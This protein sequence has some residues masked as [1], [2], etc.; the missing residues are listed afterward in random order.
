MRSENQHITVEDAKLIAAAIDAIAV[1]AGR[2]AALHKSTKGQHYRDIGCAG[3]SIIKTL[4]RDNA[5][6]CKAFAAVAGPSNEASI[7]AIFN[8]VCGDDQ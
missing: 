6:A 2:L 5:A 7:R 8:A 1:G 3:Q 4:L